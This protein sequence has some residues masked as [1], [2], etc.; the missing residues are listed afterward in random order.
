V[1]VTELWNAIAVGVSM[2]L[3]CFISHPVPVVNMWV[4]REAV[5]ILPDV[6]EQLVENHAFVQLFH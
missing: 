5:G 6:I 3:I 4:A 1:L 2:M